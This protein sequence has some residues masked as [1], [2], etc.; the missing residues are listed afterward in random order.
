MSEETEDNIEDALDEAEDEMGNLSDLPFP[1]QSDAEWDIQRV[2]FVLDRL[3]KS[4]QAQSKSRELEHEE[5]MEEINS[6]NELE[7]QL[8]AV[9]EENQ[10]LKSEIERYRRSVPLS[11]YAGFGLGILFIIYGLIFVG[12]VFFAIVGFGILLVSGTA[13]Y[14]SKIRFQRRR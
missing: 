3:V 11:V 8:K 2:G 6:V 4:H 1:A 7:A 5:V 13:V 12:D 14:E 9:Q 10:D